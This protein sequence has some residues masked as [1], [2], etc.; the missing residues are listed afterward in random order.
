MA[1]VAIVITLAVAPLLS[2]CWPWPD[3]DSYDVPIMDGDYIYSDFV[4]D[5]TLNVFGHSNYFTGRSYS[6]KINS[7]EILSG[8]IRDA[9]DKNGN[10]AGTFAHDA[11]EPS[12][13][14]FKIQCYIFY[15]DNIRRV[16][17]YDIKSAK[18]LEA[19]NGLTVLILLQTD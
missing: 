2:A 1:S 16:K 4:R 8:G 10:F 7:V 3:E 12:S 17:I 6:L 11:T 13:Y 15:Q 14:S 5:V 18:L 9:T 19:L